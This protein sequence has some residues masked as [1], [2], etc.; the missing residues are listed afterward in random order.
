[1]AAHSSNIVLTIKQYESKSYRMFA[2]W[3]VEAHC[4]RIFLQLS[5]MPR[6]MTFQKFVNR[7]NNVMLGKTIS[8]F[9]VLTGT[10]RRHIFGYRFNRIQYYTWIA[11]LCR[12]SQTEEKEICQTIN[13]R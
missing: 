3:L 7:I 2:K 11:V 10:R 6:F 13:R 12:V 4:V 9:V 8:L 1:M 5:K